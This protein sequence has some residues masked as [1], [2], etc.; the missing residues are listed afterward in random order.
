MLISRGSCAGA[1][2]T[3]CMAVVRADE[4]RFMRMDRDCNHHRARGS[5]RCRSRRGLVPE[6]A[7]IIG[8]HEVWCGLYDR[9]AACAILCRMW[10]ALAQYV[11]SLFVRGSYCRMPCSPGPEPPKAAA[12]RAVKQLGGQCARQIST[13]SSEAGHADQPEQL[14]RG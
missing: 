10:L 12:V 11:S 2:G 1:W 14:G 13:S 4:T 9:G 7:G 6:G 5:A 3:A 8:C